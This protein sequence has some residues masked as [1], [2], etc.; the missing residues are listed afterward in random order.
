VTGVAGGLELVFEDM[1]GMAR[2]AG[3]LHV[4]TPQLEARVLVVVKAR[5]L[6]TLRAV[7]FA[8]LAP[9]AAPVLVIVLVTRKAGLPLGVVIK[10][11][12]VA[13]ATANDAVLT[14]E[15][16]IGLRVVIEG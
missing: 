14:L 8:A 4:Q 6:P 3:G 1:P 13:S 9:V 11:A 2:F 12:A 10:I 5:F 7:A 15:R 16:E